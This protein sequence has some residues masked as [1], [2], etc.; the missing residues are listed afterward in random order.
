M[1]STKPVFA[2]MMLAVFAA[3]FAVAAELQP[4]R[5]RSW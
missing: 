5:P 3:Q 2:S 1:K 4:G